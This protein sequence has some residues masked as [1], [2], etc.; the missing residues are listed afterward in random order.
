MLPPA[1]LLHMMR[2]AACKAGNNRRQ[3]ESV[4]LDAMRKGA[5]TWVAKIFIGLLVASFAVWGV[6][7][8][9][10]GYGQRTVAT[11]GETEIPAQA[12]QEALRQ[13]MQSVRE[14]IGRGMTMAEARQFG[15]D[16]QVF[17]ELLREAALDNQGDAM[18]LGISDEAIAERIMREEAFQDE[19]GRFDKARFLQIL[20]ANGFSEGTFIARQH[21]AYVRQQLVQTVGQPVQPPKAFIDAANIYRNETRKLKYFMIGMDGIEPVAD[22]D[23]ETLKKYFELNK[24]SYAIPEMRKFG[25]I[26]LLPEEIAKTVPVTDEELKARY[27]ET[28]DS[29]KEPERRRVKQMSFPDEK[30]AQEAYEKIKAGSTFEEIAGERDL[31]EADTG[32]GLVAKSDLVDPKVAEAAFALAQGEVSEP[33]QGTFATVLLKVEEIQP[34]K[35]T[36]FEDAKQTVRERIALERA[37]DVINEKHDQIED[38][39][40]SG[41]GLKAVAETLGLDYRT[42]DAVDRS[43][44]GSDGQPVKG[45]PNANALLNGVFS[46]EPGLENDP[47]ETDDHGLVWYD[48]IEIIPTRIPPLEE[49]REEV[50]ADWRANEE[51]ERL[52]EKARNLVKQAEA[53]K[54]LDEIASG[55]GVEVKKTEAFKRA[56]DVEGLPRAAI[57]QAFALPKDGYGSA[58]ADDGRQRVVFQ[59]VAIEPPA[60]PD[61]NESIALVDTFGPQF[62]DDLVTQYVSGLVDKFGVSRNDAVFN[63]ITGRVTE[64]TGSQ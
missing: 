27:E 62:T 51:R 4:M 57:A 9:F 53:G 3:I 30:A 44:K 33:V 50:R 41:A 22:T 46:S 34:A 20:R 28:R 25:I 38:E 10:G 31:T 52:A 60:A 19:T 32:L 43:G 45:L 18:H 40:A 35:T 12:Y 37:S 15:I 58:A 59:V 64:D 23:E 56:A 48:V 61:S 36:S 54:S 14:Q 16:Q 2:R 8:I 11:V 5:A 47:I 24:N 42:V 1:V 63:Q 21:D 17:L 55:L 39:R 6:A 29:F 26:A 7:D 49:V 13:R